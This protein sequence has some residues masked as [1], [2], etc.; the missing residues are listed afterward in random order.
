[1]ELTLDHSGSPLEYCLQLSLCYELF[2]P[3]HFSSLGLLEQLHFFF[4]CEVTVPH[5]EL[6]IILHFTAMQIQSLLPLSRKKFQSKT[7]CYDCVITGIL[8]Y[9]IDNFCPSLCH[10]LPPNTSPFLLTQLRKKFGK[11]FLTS[12]H[13]TDIFEHRSSH[14]RLVRTEF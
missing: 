6:Y 9:V 10:S 5:I 4:L 14:L 7:R 12:S 8:V 11:S 2:Y 13:Q 3:T 1:M